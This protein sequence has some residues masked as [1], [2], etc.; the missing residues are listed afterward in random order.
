MMYGNFLTATASRI[1]A[2]MTKG[3]DG[4]DVSDAR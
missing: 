4:L 3:L 1:A 2:Y